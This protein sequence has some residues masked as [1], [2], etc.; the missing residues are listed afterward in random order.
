M[1]EFSLSP[2]LVFPAG[3]EPPAPSS[4]VGLSV[5]AG[6]AAA[7]PALAFFLRAL[8]DSPEAVAGGGFATASEDIFWRIWM[9]E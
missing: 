9:V 4:E 5:G 2:L 1:Y 7:V 6:T 3:S 8:L